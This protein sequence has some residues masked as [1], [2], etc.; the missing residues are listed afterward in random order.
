MNTEEQSLNSVKE[1]ITLSH[2]IYDALI[3]GDSKL[4]NTISLERQQK[5][6]AIPFQ[7]LSTAPSSTDGKLAEELRAA[8]DELLI[9]NK[10]LSETSS[11]VKEV[12]SHELSIIK[13][14]VT[15]T[16]AYQNIKHSR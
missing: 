6:E 11:Q 15:G 5:L 1:A 7:K 9:L 14:G 3:S 4:A 10:K 12:L 2:S 13:K 16:R 8:F